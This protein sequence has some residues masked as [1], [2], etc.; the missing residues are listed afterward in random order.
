MKLVDET[1]NKYHSLEVLRKGS[2][3]RYPSG[4]IK[5]RWVCICDCGNI[6]EVFGQSLRSG[7]TKS[8]GCLKLAL[9]NDYSG[10]TIGNLTVLRRLETIVIKSKSDSEKQYRHVNWQCLC[11]CG[12]EFIRKSRDIVNGS[13]ENSCGCIKKP[14]HRTHGHTESGKQTGT[15]SSWHC[16]NQRCNNPNSGAYPTYGGSGITVCDRWNITKGG[17]F[18]NFLEDMGERP[19]GRSLNRINGAKIYS[20][21][22]CEW[23]TLSIQAYDQKIRNTNT[24]GRTGISWNKAQQSWEAYIDIHYKRIRLGFHSEWKEAVAVREKAELQYFGFIKQ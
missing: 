5:F 16:A 1:G 10:K 9:E 2:S 6:T 3:V 22:T 21:E 8:C 18:E 15:Y 20:K 23:A 11:I 14:A 17:S 4:Q 7:V 19:E 24:S 12:K 13:F